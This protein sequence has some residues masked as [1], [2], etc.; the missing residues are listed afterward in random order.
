MPSEKKTQIKGLYGQINK[1]MAKTTQSM[2]K[3][4][5]KRGENQV[6]TKWNKTQKKD[7]SP[8]L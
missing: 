4:G 7:T 5:E 6:K 1:K 8:G 3:P 2:M